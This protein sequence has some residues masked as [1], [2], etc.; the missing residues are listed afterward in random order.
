MADAT[1]KLVCFPMALW[2]D[3]HVTFVAGTKER[4]RTRARL[5]VVFARAE[6]GY[7]L[8]WIPGRGWTVPS[9]HVEPGETD[10]EAARRETWEETGASIEGIW[11]IGEYHLH[12]GGESQTVVPAYCAAVKDFG[13]IPPG[14][15]S[16]EA[17]CFGLTKLPEVYYQWDPL[18]ASVFAYAETE[19]VRRRAA[20]AS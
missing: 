14:S 16:T 19:F 2:H 9:G 10:E 7:V 5:V 3:T 8:A 11:R 1:S 12:R 20:G 4:T 13:H 17:R 6:C 15:E 18:V